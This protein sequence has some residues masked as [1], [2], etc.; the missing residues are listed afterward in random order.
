MKVSLSW[1]K[2]LVDYQLSAEDLAEKLS[3][4][5]IGV[6]QQTEDYLE[7]DLTYNRGD[8]L[9][10]RGVAYEISAITDAPL[11]FLAQTPEDFIWVG[12]N[13]PKVEMGGDIIKE[14]AVFCVAKIEGLKIGESN[15]EWVKKLTDSGIRSINNIA[16]ITNL[17]MIEYGQPMHAFD[18][19]K[20][21]GIHV[22]K[23]KKGT[24]FTTLDG[25]ERNLDD[26]LVIRNKENIIGIAGVMGGKD[27]EVSDSTTSIMLEA[28]I[29]NP[30]MIRKTSKRIGLHSEASRRFQHELSKFRLLQALDAAIR[31]YHKIGGK[32]T[33]L[34]L[35]GDFGQEKRNLNLSI[36]KA[37]SLLGVRL[38]EETITNCLKKL[39][40]NVQHK[41]QDNLEVMP[42]YFRMDI[43]IEEDL[44]EEVARMYG[45]EKIEAT[46]LAKEKIPQLDQRLPKFVYDI[47]LKLQDLGLTEVQ[48]YSFYSSA[49]FKALEYSEEVQKDFIKI[50]NPLS[51][52]TEYMRMDLWPN[53]LEVVGKNI[54]QGFKDIAIFEVGKIY[55]RN[56]QKQADEKYTVSI[57]LMNSSDNPLEELAGLIKLVLPF[58]KGNLKLNTN[59]SDHTSSQ[60]FHPHRFVN[61]TNNGEWVGGAA[62]IHLKTLHKLGI[63]KR[64]AVMELN[65]RKLI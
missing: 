44:I 26:D 45:Y 56:E 48:T 39:G 21:G 13:L 7:L 19:T 65:L 47:K 51:S 49:V 52:E 38:D 62:E 40:F 9:S 57:A 53:L 64:V 28:A 6:K 20:A 29:F 22:D 23:A 61:I 59:P 42:P 25:K 27:S 41:D 36:N 16:D 11:R 18:A 12:Q 15:K 14:A 37:N 35:N 54:R 31:M 33:A 1:L 30:S 10:M 4:C 60:N 58:F 50:A 63:E 32:L 43:N 24:K 17:I 46:T 8:L 2:E 3:L 5:S 55:W 34:T